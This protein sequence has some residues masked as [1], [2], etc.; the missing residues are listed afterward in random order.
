MVSL[1]YSSFTKQLNTKTIFTIV[2]IVAA[3][4]MATVAIPSVPQAHADKGGVPN[5]NAGDNPFKH[6]DT[7][8]G[9]TN[10]CAVG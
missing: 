5:S 4:I 10:H 2:A 3:S 9:G 7:H 8:P 6:C 1:L